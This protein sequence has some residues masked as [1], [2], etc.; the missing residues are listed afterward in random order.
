MSRQLDPCSTM[1]VAFCSTLFILAITGIVRFFMW[2]QDGADIK[3]SPTIMGFV[4]FIRRLKKAF[5][6]DEKDL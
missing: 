2:I 4:R 1:A 5:E 3:K 6:L